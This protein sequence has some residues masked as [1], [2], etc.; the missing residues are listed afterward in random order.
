MRETPPQDRSGR[1]LQVIPATNPRPADP[2]SSQRDHLSPRSATVLA[3]ERHAGVLFPQPS[4]SGW[5]AHNLREGAAAS[6]VTLPGIVR[7]CLG[8]CPSVL[9]PG[10]AAA[11]VA[12]RGRPR[13]A[14]VPPGAGAAG[15][16]GAGGAAAP[17][18]AGLGSA[19]P[20]GLPHC[21]APGAATR[22]DCQACLIRYR[23]RKRN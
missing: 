22:F 8:P 1:G 23:I 11:D 5:V 16:P 6:T 15:E 19:G 20:A 14:G 12:C 9:W 4:L 13:P 7:L 2:F 17:R 21:R 3:F 18:G 10:R